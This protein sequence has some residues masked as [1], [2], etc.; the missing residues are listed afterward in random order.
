MSFSVKVSQF[1]KKAIDAAE[2][3]FQ[4]QT[5][6]LWTDIVDG[7][8]RITGTLRANW[9]FGA[10][11]LNNAKIDPVATSAARAAA[12]ANNSKLKLKDTAIIFNNMEYAEVVENGLAGTRRVP[13]RMVA[14][15]IALA[16]AK[17]GIKG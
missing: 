15:A 10:G 8:P 16:Q 9:Q 1:A 14:K 6:Q 12:K 7:T 5:F 3:E 17:K 4:I 11:V 2:K 13:R